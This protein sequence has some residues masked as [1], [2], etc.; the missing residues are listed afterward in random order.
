MVDLPWLL[1]EA[2]A[3]LAAQELVLL[4]GEKDNMG[5]SMTSLLSRIGARLRGWVAAQWG[6]FWR[7]AVEDDFG[8][9]LDEGALE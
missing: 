4:H 6:G 2:P 9:Q 8:E 7:V 3:L 5:A 1:S